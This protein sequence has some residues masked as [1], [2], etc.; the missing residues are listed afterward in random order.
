MPVSDATDSL[1]RRISP[2]E[3]FTRIPVAPGSFGEWLRGLPLKE[4][5]PPIHLYDGRLKFNQ[6]AHWAVVDIDTGRK[7]LQQ[8]ADAVIRLRAE[9]LFASGRAED[10]AFNFTS[11]DPAAWARWAEGYRPVVTN[12]RVSWKRYSDPEGSYRSFRAYLDSV[13]T[14]AGSISLARELQPV[15]DP[16]EVDLGDVF[17]HG[18]S[19]GHAVLVVDVARRDSDGSKLFLLVQSYMPA[20]EIHVLRNPGR[21]DPWYAATF[22][23]T[24]ATPEWTFLRTDLKRF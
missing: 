18:G 9:Y 7:D 3:S 2:P 11:G 20:Q 23:E 6:E 4:G 21:D 1:E 24:L 15:V 17:I 8:C 5:R 19:P 16:S 10:V 13:F 22:G 12:G 14:Y